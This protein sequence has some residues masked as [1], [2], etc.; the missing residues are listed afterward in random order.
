MQD[1]VKEPR[2]LEIDVYG[3]PGSNAYAKIGYLE[4]TDQYTKL[5]DEYGYKFIEYTVKNGSKKHGYI[6]GGLSSA[7]YPVS[8]TTGCRGVTNGNSPVTV[9]C[10]PEANDNCYLGLLAVGETFSYLGYTAGSAMQFIEY[11]ASAGTKRGYIRTS[12][13]TPQN[14]TIL[15]KARGYVSTYTSPGDDADG[16]LYEEEYCVILSM[17]KKYCNIEYNTV[18]GRKTAYVLKSNLTTIGDPS[19]VP[20]VQDP[21]ISANM[22]A[23]QA[24]YGGP[25]HRIYASIG[26][27]DANE[28]IS[29]LHRE[30]DYFYIQY[31]TSTSYKRGYVPMVSIIKY[32]DYKDEVKDK[33]G[34]YT[35]GYYMRSTEAATVYSAPDSTSASLG[36]VYANEGVTYLGVAEGNFSFVEYSSMAGPKRGY[37]LSNLLNKTYD[38]SGFGKCKTDTDVYYAPSNAKIGTIYA[39]EYVCILNRDDQKN[40]YYIEYNS[41]N[42]RKR[43]YASCDTVEKL[44]G[45]VNT[46]SSDSAEAPNKS[47]AKAQ[48][49]Y[50]GPSEAYFSVGS[51]IK[52]EVVQYL[53]EDNGMAFIQYNFPGGYKR[54]YVPSNT[55]IDAVITHPVVT[56][57]LLEL[58]KLPIG[59]TPSI[60]GTSGEGNPIYYYTLGDENAR[61]QMILNFAIHG[62]EDFRDKQ[63]QDG[64]ELTK[65]AMYLITELIKNDLNGWCIRIIPALNPDGILYR[66]SENDRHV[67]TIYEYEDD[68]NGKGRHNT[69][70]LNWNNA[71]NID[72]NHI[73]G[74]INNVNWDDLDGALQQLNLSYTETYDGIDMNRCF[75]FHEP[76]GWV[77]NTGNDFSQK[78]QR[79]YIG[80][81]ALRAKEALYLWAL[82][83]KV[84]VMPGV[85][86]K[87]F[88]DTHGWTEQ[89]ITKDLK[90][91]N[92]F[93]SAF[94]YNNMTD[95]K[96]KGY[97]A[98][99]AMDLGFRSCLFEFPRPIEAIS[100]YN[101]NYI[102]AK[103]N[104][105]H[106][107]DAI[108]EI[109]SEK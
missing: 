88:I 90:I 75:P 15:G 65:L 43:G 20:S 73:M 63:E 68:C 45:E 57:D 78:G 94:E 54:G 1:M 106:Y 44:S 49:V 87:V 91:Y 109:I 108:K 48:K 55:L 14:N 97:V 58:E 16:Y 80:N 67:D 96:G 107:I 12:D 52:D 53:G 3:G 46:V 40:I 76:S 50:S 39:D 70:D 92:Y 74:Q 56:A 23:N 27:V 84:A 32:T 85:T 6:A 83:N 61:K 93:N 26:S 21:G 5:R 28:E 60:L 101:F 69:V 9:Y 17:G 99:Y 19:K 4:L 104:V 38:K 71:E 103:G 62:H 29:I 18:T 89:I 2:I 7:T 35:N 47:S 59:I 86:N 8:F 102:E 64:Y 11:S 33:T 79:N 36:S 13:G 95:L 31:Y 81:T 66:H 105:D 22:L 30:G 42:G 37:I 34:T 77:Y 82:I 72:W 25:G 98:R 24:V 10:Y 51:I 100:N 41:S